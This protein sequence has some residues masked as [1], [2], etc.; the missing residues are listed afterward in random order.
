MYSLHCVLKHNI[1]SANTRIYSH[2]NKTSFLQKWAHIK[3]NKIINKHTFQWIFSITIWNA[4]VFSLDYRYVAE[5]TLY[6]CLARKLI[7]PLWSSHI[8]TQWGWL[9]LFRLDHFSGLHKNGES[10]PNY[11]FLRTFWEGRTY[12]LSTPFIA[13]ESQHHEESHLI[14]GPFESTLLDQGFQVKH[15]LDTCNPP[16]TRTPLCH[17]KLLLCLQWR[18]IPLRHP[19]TSILSVIFWRLSCLSL[20]TSRTTHLW[21][22]TSFLSL[23]SKHDFCYIYGNTYSVQTFN[24]ALTV[25]T[26]ISLRYLTAIIPSQLHNY[27]LPSF[28]PSYKTCSIK[29]PFIL[30]AIKPS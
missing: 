28:V 22:T 14:Y 16:L 24:N 13:A 12:F 9:I 11:L 23:T 20:T 5:R 7:L 2:K 18:V 27:F 25:A 10:P 19:A 17:L 30:A 29:V 4:L 21:V 8:F 3:R 26:H 6:F 1:Y 15:E